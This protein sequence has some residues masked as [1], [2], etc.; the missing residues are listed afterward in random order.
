VKRDKSFENIELLEYHQID[1]K[2]WDKSI[3]K[4]K[5]GLPYAFSTFLDLICPDWKALVNLEYS[6]LMPVCERAKGGITYLFQPNFC[7]QLGLFYTD[8]ENGIEANRFLEFVTKR[9]K[10]AE[11]N[12]NYDN[13]LHLKK[14]KFTFSEGTNLELSLDKPIEALRK[15]YGSNCK[16]NL[17]KA[18]KSNV[19][20]CY[21]ISAD[22][23]INLFRENKGEEVDAWKDPEYRILKQIINN[24]VSSKTGM[25]IGVK[26]FENE[27]CA[28]GFFLLDKKRAIFLFSGSN[29]EA[30]KERAMFLLMHTAITFFAKS[31]KQIFDFEGSNNENLA[32]FYSGFGAENRPYPIITINNL[33]FLKRKALQLIKTLR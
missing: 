8:E 21:D 23:V 3:A 25:L 31:G 4:A 13:F 33:P 16:R 24:S 15:N 6:L 1:K 17:K 26:N 19:S 12:M 9:W 20:I 18:E 27:Y 28:G 29:Q 7:Q 14:E 32:R 11:F 10:F 30:K 22:K 5:N 2:R